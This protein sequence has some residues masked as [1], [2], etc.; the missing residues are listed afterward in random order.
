MTLD[1]NTYRSRTRTQTIAHSA[2]FKTTSTYSASNAA[3]DSYHG[4][5]D[6]TLTNYAPVPVDISSWL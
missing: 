5:S 4:L 6:R 2:I 3:F 1:R